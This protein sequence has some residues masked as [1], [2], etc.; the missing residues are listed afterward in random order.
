MD[1]DPADL[2]E[3][4]AHLTRI[5]HF[6]EALAAVEQAIEAGGL[7]ASLDLTRGECLLGLERFRD[8]YAIARNLLEK[9]GEWIRPRAL[10]LK[11]SILRRSSRYLEDALEAALDGAAAAALQG[12]ESHDIECLAHLE[13]ARIFAAKSCRGLA[14]REL[15]RASAAD[16]DQPRVAYYRGAILMDLDDRPAAKQCFDGMRDGERSPDLAAQADHYAGIGLAYLAYVMGE[17]EA[18]HDYLDDISPI[19]AGDLW[20]RRI[21][22]MVLQAQ[23]RWPEAAEA[24]GQ[25]IAE[26]PDADYVRRDQYERAGCLYAAGELAAALDAY[27][28]LAED[29]DDY[30]GRLAARMSHLLSRPDAAVQPRRRLAAFPS[31]AQLRDH[32]GPASCELYLRFFGLSDTQV[33]IA[34]AIK[35][36]DGGTPVS[37]MRHYLE[38]AGFHTR[39]LEAELPLLKRLIDAGI[40]VI[41]EESYS[42]STHVAVAIGYDD[43]RQVLEVQDPMTHRVRETLYE[44]LAELRNLS[45]HGALVGVPAD[46]RELLAALDAAGAEECRYIALIDQ[47]WAALD[48]DRAADGDALAD[49]S[50]ELHREYEMAWIYRFR[51]ARDRVRDQPSTEHRVELHRVL[52]EITSLWPDDEWPQQLLGEALYF[53]DRT[54]EALVA[55]E[56]AR[57]RD[58][59]DPYNWSMIADCHLVT[60]NPEQAYDALVEALGCDPAHVRGNENLADLAMQRGQTTLAWALNDV[61]RELHENNPF[62][63]GVH[64]QLLEQA[65]ELD[66]ALAAYD[67][68]LAL[69]ASRG[70]LVTLRAKLLGRLGRVDEAADALTALAEANPDHSL[71]TRI[72]LADL[73]YVRGRPDRAVEVCRAM[74]AEDETVP[75]GHAILGAALGQLGEI[76]PAMS[77]FRRALELRPTYTWVYTEL[78]KLQLANG[79]KAEAIQAFAAALGMSGG[80]PGCEFDLGDAL[81]DAGYPEAGVRYLRSAAISGNLDEAQLARVGKLIFDTNIGS[82]DSFFREVEE[83][84]TDDLGVL[85]A[86]AHTLLEVMWAPA[87]AAEV[88]DKIVAMAP[89]DPYALTA[90]GERMMYQSIDDEPAGEELLRAA[91]AADP[92]LLYARRVYADCLLERGRFAETLDVMAP[93]RRGFHNDRLR[94]KALLG[95]GDIAGAEQ[96]IADFLA[97]FGQEGQP[98]PGSLML[99]YHVA[100]R[101]WDWSRA[102]SLA[103]AISRQMHE[104]DDDGRLDRWEE[105]RFECLARLGEDQRALAFGETQAVDAA[106][107][108]RLAY[109]AYRA[110]RMELASELAGRALAFDPD[111]SQALAVIARHLEL[112][113]DEDGAI[114]TWQHLGEVDADWHVAQEQLARLALAAGDLDAAREL[115]EEAVTTGHLCPWAFGVRAQIRLAGGD[116]DGA[117]R[118]LERAWMLAAPEDREHEG[119]DVWALRSWLAGDRAAAAAGLD[120][121]RTGEGPIS[122][123]DLRRITMMEEL[124]GA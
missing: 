60:G 49:Q 94:V 19:A 74:I 3:R 68:A 63:H 5:H 18:A 53:D 79:H 114:E 82:A 115:A 41:M 50:I 117:V 67:R 43:G 113:G 122:E 123:A 48:D 28:E 73:L 64:G 119:R 33:E 56:R 61:A 103:E 106:S 78:G 51:R 35:R 24:L 52:G 39:R 86:H 102:L 121:Y 76:E 55:F 20:P 65:G 25:V 9:G 57:D 36:P 62:N 44:D 16:P 118:D 107:L 101:Q 23:Q 105:E 104:R 45:N 58:P 54:G 120:A 89:D 112:S 17:F 109:A 8:A 4:A 91:L 27:G 40:P 98:N 84:R 2:G 46:D 99:Q 59:Q 1:H 81:V 88:L 110:D 95:Q 75:S 111:E 15:D 96:V 124:L 22:A 10:V 37:R 92:E 97:E 26:G 14:E 21:R 6:R 80:N 69:D 71:G 11:A 13:A 42:S 116:R 38:H 93:C 90:R 30:H 47:A 77:E 12:A 34:R 66:A 83:R 70:W 72:D 29:E 31:V 85:R 87:T 7:T 100:R 32:C 108:G